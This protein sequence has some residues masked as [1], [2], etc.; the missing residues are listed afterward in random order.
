MLTNSVKLA[1]IAFPF[2]IAYICAINSLFMGVMYK[3]ISMLCFPSLMLA[4]DSLYLFI[5]SR[6][7]QKHLVYFYNQ[8]INGISPIYKIDLSY[9]IISYAIKCSHF[10]NLAL[11]CSAIIMEKIDFLDCLW[12]VSVLGAFYNSSAGMIKSIAKYRSM[13]KFIKSINRI[14]TKVKRASD[15]ICIICM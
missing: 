2:S 5:V 7:T 3:V 9:K 15:Q 12:I 6:Q 8:N 10:F 14:L 4:I 11:L 13:N 1:A